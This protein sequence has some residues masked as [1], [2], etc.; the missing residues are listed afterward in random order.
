MKLQKLY[1]ITRQAIDDYSMIQK[2]DKIA[3]GISGGKD[4]LT[5]LYALSGLKRFYPEAFELTAI[6]V[7]LG[8][9]GFHLEEIQALCKELQVPYSIVKTEI[10]TILS[11]THQKGN[12]CSLCAKLRKGALNEEAIRLHCNKIAYAH[13]A[14]DLLET[15]ML[16][17]IFEGR[18]HSFSPMT[19]LN[20]T[21]L[22]VIRPLMY[23]MEADIIGFARKQNLP[24]VSNPC[25]LDGITQRAYAKNLIR[26]INLA[27]PG[28]KKRMLTAILNGNMEDWP[29]RN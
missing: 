11:D 4:S 1:S 7:D 28:A 20:R 5:L 8:Y 13:H 3:I 17:L 12:S 21:N 2:G 6:T 25:P 26:E 27:H 9:E 22:T 15:M 19:K 18:F 23:L 14:D 16:S 10:A 29:I 24:I